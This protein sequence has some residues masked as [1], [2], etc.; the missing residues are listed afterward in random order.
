MKWYKVNIKDYTHEQYKKWYELMSED[1]KARV[2]RFKVEDDKRRTVFGEMLARK[3]LSQW[4]DVAPE[5]ISFVISEYGK[6]YAK[7]LDV[8]FSISHSY[9]MVVCAVSDSPVGIDIEKIRPVNLNIAKRICTDDELCYIFSHKP[10]DEDFLHTTD[11]DVLT[12]FFDLWTA[13]EAYVKL[14]GKGLKDGLRHTPQHTSIVDNGY[15]ISI[16]VEK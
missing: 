5:Y 10:E 15:V 2:D 8:H 12:R 16:C 13:K 11:D 3:A 6:P 9:D 4:C 14:N 7:G 1:K